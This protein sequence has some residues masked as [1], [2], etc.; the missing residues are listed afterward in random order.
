ML[1]GGRGRGATESNAAEQNINSW[2]HFSW[3]A[4]TSRLRLRKS[5]TSQEGY[6]MHA[7]RN[8]CDVF[9][10]RFRLLGKVPLHFCRSLRN[11]GSFDIFE[12]EHPVQRLVKSFR[13]IT[14]YSTNIY[15]VQ[16]SRKA[17]NFQ[18]ECT[19]HKT[20]FILLSF[21]PINVK[22]VTCVDTPVQTHAHPPFLTL[23]WT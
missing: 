4:R 16:L 17:E 7:Q 6:E 1:V 22:R 9:A 14:S 19:W 2:V 12:Q 18:E 21:R 8:N 3:I 11:F 15:F 20:C 13:V 10:P 23:I 5:R